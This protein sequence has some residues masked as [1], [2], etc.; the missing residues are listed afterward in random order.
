MHA[1]PLCNKVLF[2]VSSRKSKKGISP[3]VETDVTMSDET[4]EFVKAFADADKV[5]KE[6]TGLLIQ[7]RQTIVKLKTVS[8]KLQ[9]ISSPEEKLA[10]DQKEKAISQ[11]FEQVTQ[12]MTIILSQLEQTRDLQGLFFRLVGMQGLMSEVT[13]LHHDIEV[14]IDGIQD[15]VTDANFDDIGSD[16][17]MDEDDPAGSKDKD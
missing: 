7:T 12:Q 5:A 4:E 17:P 8:T 15:Q 6:V 14:T 2:A 1:G 16:A 10:L 13:Q 11:R 3:L 9:T